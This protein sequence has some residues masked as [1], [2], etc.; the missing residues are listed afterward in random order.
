MQHTHRG[1]SAPG[2]DLFETDP[3]ETDLLGIDLEGKPLVPTLFEFVPPPASA[4]G[5]FDI[6]GTDTIVH[7]LE[8]AFDPPQSMPVLPGPDSIRQRSIQFGEVGGTFDSLLPVF[9]AVRLED[10]TIVCGGPALPPHGVFDAGISLKTE[11]TTWSR[12]PPAG[13]LRIEG[14]NRFLAGPDDP[15]QDFWVGS[16]SLRALGCGGARLA[17]VDVGGGR[18]VEAATPGDLI[19][20]GRAPIQASSS[21]IT[22]PIPARDEVQLPGSA[23]K[24]SSR[25]SEQHSTPLPLRAQ[26]LRVPVVIFA[27]H[28]DADERKREALGLGLGAQ[29][30]C[31]EFDTLYREIDRILAPGSEAG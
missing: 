10:D 12:K 13:S 2:Y 29:S 27:A 18:G 30:Y 19:E 4:N 1:S 9:A 5:L 20:A 8:L 21:L 15:S 25:I 23:G 28:R 26:D 3:G 14:V 24:K 17:R 31:F 11:N 6:N 7:R 22:T 16:P